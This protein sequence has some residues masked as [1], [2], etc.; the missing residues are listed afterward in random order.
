MFLFL[1]LRLSVDGRER[2]C[3]HEKDNTSERNAA[4]TDANATNVRTH[5]SCSIIS[6]GDLNPP[7]RMR[8]SQHCTIYYFTNTFVKNLLGKSLF[9]RVSYIII[10]TYVE[11]S[12][13]CV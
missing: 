9:R 2:F 10:I 12:R 1:R 4:V 8:F 5:K 7:T 3:F 6:S 13:V 11:V